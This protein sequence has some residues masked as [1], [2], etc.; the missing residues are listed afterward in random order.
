M[1]VGL[2]PEDEAGTVFLRL[3]KAARGRH[4]ADLL[5]GAVHLARAAQ[6]VAAR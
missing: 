2:E 4:A 6:D 5:A 1:L 3:R